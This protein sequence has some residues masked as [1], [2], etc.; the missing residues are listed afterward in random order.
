MRGDDLILYD[1]KA[2]GLLLI[3]MGHSSTLYPV[4][5][6]AGQ[7]NCLENEVNILGSLTQVTTRSLDSDTTH[8][9]VASEVFKPARGVLSCA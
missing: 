9:I 8:K 2:Q 3:M 6:H 1:Q 5:T 4:V 7:A